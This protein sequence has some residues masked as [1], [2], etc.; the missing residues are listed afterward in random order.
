MVNQP[1]ADKPDFILVKDD[2]NAA[3]TGEQDLSISFG[4]SE[5]QLLME[6]DLFGNYIIS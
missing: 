4:I 5:I 2:N 1:L 6:V 3:L